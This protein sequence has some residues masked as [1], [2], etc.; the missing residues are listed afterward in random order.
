MPSTYIDPPPCAG[1]DGWVERSCLIGGRERRWLERVV[2]P[3]TDRVEQYFGDYTTAPAIRSAPGRPTHSPARRQRRPTP[4][5][6]SRKAYQPVA[7]LNRPSGLTVSVS[8]TALYTIRTEIRKREGEIEEQLLETGGGLFG[9][10]IQ[11]WHSH[12]EVRLGSV[13]ARARRRNRV[14]IAYGEIEADDAALRRVEGPHI[15]HIGDWHVHPYCDP[16]HVGEPS[17]ADM[18]A[19]LGELDRI[20]H[21]RLATGYLGIIAT[22]GRRGWASP[23]QLHAWVMRRDSN[24]TPV[25]ERASLIERRHARAA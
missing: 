10:P 20:N 19:W 12:A 11:S 22:A 24:G 18:H 8:S 7:L 1:M 23:P 15:G 21:S 17:R 16:S 3:T 14:D 5:A 2:D 6:T 4:A 9:P 13:A 25:C